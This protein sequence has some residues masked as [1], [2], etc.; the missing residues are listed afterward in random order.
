MAM[1]EGK[2][3]AAAL[4]VTIL[5]TL[6]PPRRTPAARDCIPPIE[7]PTL[8]NNLSMPKKSSNLNCALTISKIVM[9]GNVVAYGFPVVG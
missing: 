5:S 4:T 3:R 7:F 8:A 2:E 6:E 1:E 9:I